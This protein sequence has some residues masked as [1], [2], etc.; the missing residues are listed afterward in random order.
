MGLNAEHAVVELHDTLHLEMIADQSEYPKEQETA[1]YHAKHPLY[2]VVH[3]G[4]V[5]Q[6]V[7]DRDKLVNGQEECGHLERDEGTEAEGHH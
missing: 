4:V 6:A 3:D 7:H 5:A 1:A 2:P